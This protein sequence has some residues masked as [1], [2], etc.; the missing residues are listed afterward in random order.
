MNPGATND[1]QHVIKQ[2][3]AFLNAVVDENH[4]CSMDPIYIQP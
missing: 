2:D 4:A 1:I 3:Q